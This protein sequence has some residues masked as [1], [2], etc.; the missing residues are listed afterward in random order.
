MF[1]LP[2][3]PDVGSRRPPPKAVTA[4][5]ETTPCGKALVP[6]ACEREGDP[7]APAPEDRAPSAR[8]PPSCPASSP[9]GRCEARPCAAAPS[10]P[11]SRAVASPRTASSGSEGLGGSPPTGE[12]D[13]RSSSSPGAPSGGRS[14]MT[15]LGAPRQL[16]CWGPR[17]HPTSPPRPPPRRVPWGTRPP[18][19]P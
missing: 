6:A 14:P 15:P 9:A 13:G 11:G 1:A 16:R 5:G 2:P 3:A 4:G 19:P 7:S 12:K 18:S 10:Q 17:E 8:P